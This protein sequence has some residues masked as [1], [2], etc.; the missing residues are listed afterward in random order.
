MR[1]IPARLKGHGREATFHNNMR[2]MVKNLRPIRSAN[3][4]TRFTT[5][6]V[7]RAA[8]A[9]SGKAEA[10]TENRAVWL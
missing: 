9:G 7:V 4:Q 2:E 8:Q 3:V 10:S 6:G 5:G 1:R